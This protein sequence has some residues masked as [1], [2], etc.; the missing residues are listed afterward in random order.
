MNGRNI[1]L[2]VGVT[3]LVIGGLYATWKATSGTQ[4]QKVYAIK[5]TKEDNQKG[6][7]SSAVVM[8][9][10]ADFQCPA[11]KAYQPILKQLEQLFEKKVKFV[12]RHFPL[13]GHK[14]A[15]PAALAAQAAGEQGKFWGMHDLLFAG[16][17]D[18]AESESPEKIYMAYA[19]E[20]K[21]DVKK[22]QQDM[23]SDATKKR[24]ETDMVTGNQYGVNAT[25]TF[26]LNGK[27]LENPGS[28]DEFKAIIEK[29]LSTSK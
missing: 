1:L 13:A 12:Y 3:V 10:Y 22:F 8:V 25:P 4:E 21:L 15:S 2:A 5:V 11:C 20:L 19:K 14:N 6:A 28:L 16:Q 18:W 9:E 24:I 26:Y 29:E 7:T 27:K 17:T 23:Q